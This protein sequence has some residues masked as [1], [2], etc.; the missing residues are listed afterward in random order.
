[1]TRGILGPIP[2]YI[3]KVY[4][5]WYKTQSEKYP[6]DDDNEHYSWLL[7]VPAMF[8][9]RA[10]GNT[11]LTVI[12]SQNFGSIGKPVNMSKG[13]GGL[14]RVAPVGLYFEEAGSGIDEI[15]MLGAEIAA[16]AHGHALGYIPAAA[17]VHIIQ[18]LVHSEKM[19]ILD[20]VRDMQKAISRL[21]AK[22][23]HLP[24]FMNLINEAIDL[25]QDQCLNDLKDISKLGQGWATEETLAI[26]IYCSLK[27]GND[28][29]KA[30]VASVNHSGDS[31]ST[32]SVTGNIVGAHLGL[33]AI[34]QKY[35]T[36]LELKEVIYEIAD[37]L[38]NG[39]KIC[40]YSSYHDEIWEDKYLYASY[41]PDS[42]RHK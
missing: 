29:A 15:D 20:A 2:D 14:M 41:V 30:I 37:D 21:F 35:L 27:Y 42:Y 26:A 24:D 18:V 23:K 19:T 39:C 31:D 1:M 25:S 4:L 11:C 17:L 34:P 28:F 32:G 5:D 38:Y 12:G 22:N 13:C 10:P 33:K 3:A 8:A 9:R 7:N 36:N 16:L 40:E 6:L